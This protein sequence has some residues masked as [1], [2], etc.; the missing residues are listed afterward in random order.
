[1]E[2][3]ITDR[4][5]KSAHTLMVN[6]GYSAFSYA[7]ISE[8]VKIRK[9]SIHYHFPTKADLVVAVLKAHRER[10][11]AATEALD[12]QIV[13]PLARLRAYVQYWEGCIRDKTEPFCVAALLAAEL[14]SLPKKVQAEVHRYFD[15]LGQWIQRTLDDGVAKRVIK[16]QHSSEDE[17]QMLMALVHGAMLSA[18][19]YGTSDVFQTV[20]SAA[21]QRISVV[22][23]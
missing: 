13:S 5:L 17:A 7:D 4:I 1:M 9:A 18:R 6:L 11:I 22:K 23:R 16:L 21:L 19:A 10:L 3:E 15:S 20:T 14:P 2:G 12:Q 8:I